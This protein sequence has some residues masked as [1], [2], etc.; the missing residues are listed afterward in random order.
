MHA[1]DV[2]TWP[3]TL[4]N[5]NHE[6]RSQH[7]RAFLGPC[8]HEPHHILRDMHHHCAPLQDAR[9]MLLSLTHY[10]D[11]G[12]AHSRGTFLPNFPPA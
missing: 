3:A 11:L 8:W 6:Q 7:I 12:C 9:P 1:L 10:P 4:L 2:H 5:D